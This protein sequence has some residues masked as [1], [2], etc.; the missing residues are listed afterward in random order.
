LFISSTNANNVGIGTSTGLFAKTTIA[1][2]GSTS[3]TA[4]LSVINSA[5]TSLLFVRNDGRIGINDTTPDALIDFDFSSTN[6]SAG[7]E[8]GGFFT[9]TDTGLL[10]T[11][12]DTT[13]GTRI[14][15]TRTGAISGTANTY[16]LYSDVTGDTGGTSIAVAIYGSATGADN[17]YAGI[18]ENGKVGVGTTSPWQLLSVS[19]SI[20]VATT[21]YTT[22]ASTTYLTIS[23]TAFINDLASTTMNGSKLCTAANGI[24][25]GGSGSGTVNSGT[26]GQIPYYAANG[27]TLTATSTLFIS[28]AEKVGI[29]T[30]SPSY[31]LEVF[32]PSGGSLMTIGSGNVDNAVRF[33]LLNDGTSA[34]EDG[35]QFQSSA[36]ANDLNIRSYTAGSASDRLTILATNGYVGIASTS[37]SAVLSVNVSNATGITPALNINSATSSLLY[38]RSDGFIGIGTTTASIFTTPYATTTPKLSISGDVLISNGGLNL[39]TITS[40]TTIAG[41]FDV[42]NRAFT[43]EPS[44]GLT[45]IIN[46]EMGPTRFETDAG[47]VSWIDMPVASSSNNTVLSYSAMMNGTSTITVYGL[48]NGSG[49]VTNIGVGIGTTTPTAMLTV[50]TANATSSVAITKGWLCVDVDGGCAGTAAGTIYAKYADITGGSDIAERYNSS[51]PLESGDIVAALGGTKISL[52]TTTSKAIIGIVSSNPG[53]ILGNNE[54]N[55]TSSYPIALSGRVPVKISLENGPI[56]IG[57]RITISSVL[58][59]VGMKYVATSTS[60][61]QPTVGMALEPFDGWTT[62]SEGAATFSQTG[63]VLVFVNLGQPQLAASGGTG[64]LAE[65]TADTVSLNSD[66]NVNGFSLLNVK[67]I[68]GLGGLWKIDEGGN[69]TAQSVETQ[70]LTIGGGAASGVTIYDRQT[71]APKCI[72]IEGGVIKTSDGACGATTNA[73]TEAVVEIANNQAPSSNNQ[74]ATSTAQNLELGT[75]SLEQATSTP[76]ASDGSATSTPTSIP[77]AATSTPTPEPVIIPETTATSTIQ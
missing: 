13:Y 47:V 39:P 28:T 42:G 25:A 72:Y 17:N 63:M 43:V 69:I 37:P 46:A 29:G 38:V 77:P 12:T 33:N 31:K 70:K 75:S 44:S 6:G 61:G 51:A 1:G 60:S 45:S 27:T 71:G 59:G 52:A 8:Y 10:Q 18:F 7:T 26:T 19:G 36:T 53:M 16:G 32:S 76:P 74:T 50:S 62:D 35:W 11:G 68:S 14:S 65:M 48:A 24:C 34:G 21:T 5:S 20:T 57:D 4:A 64:S 49:G 40:T 56:A 3:A 73:G 30:T 55:A 15:T 9:V 67:S 58:A 2:G 54:N 41:G 66:L 22:N 23:G